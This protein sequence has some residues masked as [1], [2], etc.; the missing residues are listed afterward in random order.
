VSAT[1]AILATHFPQYEQASYENP[2][3]DSEPFRTLTDITRVSLDCAAVCEAT[4]GLLSLR[5][6]EDGGRDWHAASAQLIACL[7]AC[8]ECA[9]VARPT[10][11]QVLYLRAVVRACHACI[12]ACIDL[13]EALPVPPPPAATYVAPG[14]PA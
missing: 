9:D 14:P 1:S 7:T 8:R 3:P 12:V 4:S 5:T 10:A 6:A 2:A 11:E 13:L